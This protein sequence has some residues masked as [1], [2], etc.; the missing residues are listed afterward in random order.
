MLLD[1]LSK[2]ISPLGTRDNP[3]MSCQDIYNCNGDSF[4]PGFYWIDPNEGSPKDA[5][6]VSCQGPET[7]ITPVNENSKFEYP[8]G[9]IPLRFLR[10]KHSNVRQNI[11]YNCDSGVDTF[12]LMRLQGANGDTIQFG[13]KTVRML[14][15]PGEC[16]VVLEVT[17]DEGA[18]SD[19]LPVTAVVPEARSRPQSYSA[20]PVCFW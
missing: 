19:A 11:T 20:G 6:R 5:I 1:K 8:E 3:A 14:T 9:T 12:M 17:T 15:Q 7:C 2:L 13:D 4:K 10:L 18:S 16:P